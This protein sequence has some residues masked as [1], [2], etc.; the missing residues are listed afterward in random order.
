MPECPECGRRFESLDALREAAR[1]VAEVVDRVRA[2]RLTIGLAIILPALP[3][4]P[5]MRVLESLAGRSVA[6]VALALL[7]AIWIAAG[8]ASATLSIRIACWMF[9]PRVAKADRRRLILSLPLLLLY[10][11]PMVLIVAAAVAWAMR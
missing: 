5:L 11:L 2:R 1:A 7:G 8:V 3:L 10:C 9:D 6:L 4:A